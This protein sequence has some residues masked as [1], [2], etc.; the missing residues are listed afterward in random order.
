VTTYTIWQEGREPAFCDGTSEA[1][2]TLTERGRDG[3]AELRA[4]KRKTGRLIATA[5]KKETEE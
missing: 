3:Y 1:A 4:G 5:G 2:R